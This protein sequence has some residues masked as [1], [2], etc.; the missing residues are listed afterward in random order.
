MP[1]SVKKDPG[2]GFFL[3]CFLIEPTAIDDLLASTFPQNLRSVIKKEL[4]VRSSLEKE[5]CYFIN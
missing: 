2:F 1:G 3:I 5:V 4:I